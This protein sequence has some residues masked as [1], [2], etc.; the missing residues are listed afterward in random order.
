MKITGAPGRTASKYRIHL[1][2]IERLADGW[3]WG[4]ERGGGFGGRRR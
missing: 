3:M 1:K 4:N 2:K